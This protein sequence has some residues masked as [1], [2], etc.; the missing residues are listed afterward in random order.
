MEASSPRNRPDSFVR[1]ETLTSRG[2]YELLT[3]LVVPRPIGWISTRSASGR[4]NLAPYSFFAALSA[5]PPLVGVS[6]G[7][8]RGVPKDTLRNIR[9]TGAFCVNVVSANLLEAMNTTSADVAPEVDE[10]ELAGLTPLPGEVVD[11]PR[12]SEAPASLECVLEKEVGLGD[13]ANTL[14]IGE[15]K[16][17]HLSGGLETVPG[18]LAVDP[19]SLQPVGRLW[20]D[21]YTLLGE[22]KRIPRPR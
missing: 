19:V 7:A 18:R 4:L 20:G 8:R 21:A 14:V 22:I 2:R 6:V 11:A 13:S 17:V 3:S 10:F 16:A 5:T 15:V 9:D 12:V 1:P